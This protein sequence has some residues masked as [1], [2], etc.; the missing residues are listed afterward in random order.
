MRRLAIWYKFSRLTNSREGVLNPDIRRWNRRYAAAEGVVTPQAEAEWSAQPVDSVFRQKPSE[1]AIGLDLACGKGGA[2]LY[3]A[4]LGYTMVSVD[5]AIEGLRICKAAADR[6]G[7]S[8]NPVVMDLEN[9]CLPNAAFDLITVVR[10]LNRALFPQLIKALAPGA[11]LF[12]KTFNT[13]HLK[14]KPGFN[15]DFV[16]QLGE[17]ESAFADLLISRIDESG[18]SSYIIAHKPR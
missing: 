14:Q 10:Y 6:L 13:N 7:L 16:L 5:G 1:Y 12:Y 15:P 17:L 18:T 2:S 11:T 8:V 4:S 3:L 9:A